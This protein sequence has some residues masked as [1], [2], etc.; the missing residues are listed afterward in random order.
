M[1]SW[2]CL[3]RIDADYY[4]TPFVFNNQELILP[5]CVVDA[6]INNFSMQ[7]IFY[8]YKIQDNKWVAFQVFDDNQWS[9]LVTGSS[10]YSFDSNN[11]LL[12]EYQMTG[13][14]QITIFDL[15]TRTIKQYSQPNHSM[16]NNWAIS[17]IINEEYHLIYGVS[18]PIH[19]KWNNDKK[20]LIPISELPVNYGLGSSALVHVKSKN[21]VLFFGGLYQDP[22]ADYWTYGVEWDT[23]FKRSNKIYQYSIKENKWSELLNITIPKELRGFGWVITTD[24]RYIIMFCDDI[25]AYDMRLNTFVKSSIKCPKSETNLSAV[26]VDSYGDIKDQILFV[27]GCVRR[28]CNRFIATEIIC[29]IE[30]FFRDENVYL[31]DGTNGQLWCIAL[32]HIISAIE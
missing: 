7:S 21:I 6:D 5:A 17:V 24:E 14:D 20:Q 19:C 3:K 11:N 13:N 15:N 4:D 26:L 22:D 31:F 12:Y 18:K 27:I 16:P 8:K 10:D 30:S 25:W 1:A 23:M 32:D 29:L 28:W 9:Y 2:K